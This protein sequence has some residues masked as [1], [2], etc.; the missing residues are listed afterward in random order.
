MEVVKINILISHGV[1]D[2]SGEFSVGRSDPLIAGFIDGDEECD[3][4][5][6]S[7]TTC[8]DLGMDGGTL[9]CGLDCRFD[10]SGCTGCGNGVQESGEEC[11]AGA[12]NSD[13]TPDACRTDCRLPWC[14]DGV[15][16]TADTGGTCADDC[17]ETLFAEDFEG[18]WP[19]NW[20][21]GDLN[22]DLGADYWGPSTR[23]AFN[24]IRSL[25]CA[26]EGDAGNS[27]DDGME[28]YADH[29]LDLS[30]YTGQIV[31]LEFY[32][33]YDT[34]STSDQFC[35]AYSP[36]GG[37]NWVYLGCFDG[38]SNGWEFMSYDMS[39]QAGNPD[40]WFGFLFISGNWLSNGQG[41][42]VDDVE[43]WRSW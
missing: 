9:A 35:P 27:Y 31:R 8:I 25:W 17:R 41:A 21:V 3:G 34:D 38:S 28:A 23:R 33:W 32:A 13:T 16:D 1:V 7:G 4:A 26:E 40:F 2:V 6:L 29:P 43:V 39:S 5:D 18:Q 42:F 19:G 15:C 14:G 24:G 11:D 30:A 10:L 12:A 22:G 20:V 37:A 36:N